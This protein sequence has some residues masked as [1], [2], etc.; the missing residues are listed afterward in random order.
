MGKGITREITVGAKM[1]WELMAR[2]AIT[3]PTTASTTSTRTNAITAKTQATKAEVTRAIPTT[4][5]QG[6]AT[7]RTRDNTA[8]TT[9][10]SEEEMVKHVAKTRM[11]ET[12][13]HTS[14]GTR[15]FK[16]TVPTT[17]RCSILKTTSSR[18]S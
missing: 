3:N 10:L 15:D 7:S 14:T 6:L 5:E 2:A 11:T 8:S 1:K 9:N 18:I 4:K 17:T 12:I 13:T 16:N